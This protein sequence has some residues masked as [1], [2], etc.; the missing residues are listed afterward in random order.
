[1]EWLKEW[2]WW[3]W[4]KSCDFWNGVGG[5]MVDTILSLLPDSWTSTTVAGS[6]GPYW[7]NGNTWLPLNE[8]LALYVAT[9]TF[10]FGVISVRWLLKFIPGLGG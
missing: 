9:T 2:I 10:H 1:M 6:F 5:S 8:G 3:A 7:E 4:T